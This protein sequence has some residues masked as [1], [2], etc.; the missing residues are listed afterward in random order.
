M[1]CKVVREALSAQLDGEEHALGVDFITSHCESC[2]E[3][4]WWYTQAQTLHRQVRVAPAPTVPNLTASITQAISEVT[5]PA[6][7][8]QQSL[9]TCR[10]LL[11]CCAAIQLLVNLPMLIGTNTGP[12]HLDHELGSWDFALGVGL[13]FAAFR[14]ERAWG[15]LPLV[16]AVALALGGTAIFDVISGNTSIGGESTHLLEGVGVVFLWNIARLTKT[17]S[18]APR[19]QLHLA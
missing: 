8:R 15:M 13:L 11:A 17:Q 18:P 10:I 19:T 6:E 12:V 9:Q 3:C 4:E 14:P 16:A 1:E 7:A 2:F 5:L